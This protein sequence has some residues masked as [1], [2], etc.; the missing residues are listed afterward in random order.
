MVQVTASLESALRMLI[1]KYPKDIKLWIDAQCINQN[2]V[3]ERNAQVKRMINI[4]SQVSLTVV[5]LGE[6]ADESEKAMKLI[7][8][9]SSIN[10]MKDLSLLLGKRTPY[11]GVDSSMRVYLYHWLNRPCWKRLWVI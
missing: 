1:R 6:D 8:D 7:S 4:Y 10:V 5:W 3:A 9:L 11:E 2:D